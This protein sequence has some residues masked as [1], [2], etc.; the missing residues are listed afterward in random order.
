MFLGIDLGTGSLKA[1]LMAEDG[2]V[3]AEASESYQVNSPQPKWA[4]TDPWVWWRA[5]VNSLNK[6]VQRIGSAKTAIKG[7]GLSGQMH[8]VV[9]CDR[10]LQPL[11]PAILWA[12]GRASESLKV[13]QQLSPSMQR[14]LANPLVVGM[15]GV[16]LLWLKQHE[17]ALYQQA[18]WALQPKDWLR[19]QL[20]GL[21]ASKPHSE[22][23]D[24]SATLLYDLAAD[25]WAWDILEVL[26]LRGEML[27]GVVGSST[28]L[29]SLS[30][31][32]AQ[33]LNLPQNI[34]VI[35]GA[36]DAAA[37]ALGSGLI[38]EGQVQVN[39]GTAMQIFAI[40]YQAHIDPNLKTHLYRNALDGY[41]AMAAMQNAGIVLEQVRKLL[42]LS[43]TEMYEEAFSLESSEGLS[44]LPYITG[45]R[46]PHLNPKAKA[47]WH[48]LSLRHTRG[49]MARS[50]FEGV[51]FALKDGL[52]ALEATGIRAEYLRFVGGGT[53]DKRWQQLVSDIL[54]KP[55]YASDV[56]DSSARGAAL[57][58]LG[59]EALSV[60]DIID[61][62]SQSRG[63]AQPKPSPDLSE[64][65]QRFSALYPR[66]Y[67]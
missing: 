35:A 43:W 21:V 39:I 5:C 37:S 19:V 45:E 20:T 52:L 14:R 53:L 57:A 15:A 31:Q 11:R 67:G 27:G 4:E 38:Q 32:A 61:M 10:A 33:T 48:G 54:A 9:L 50:A 64:A 6:I 62:T 41:Y 23:S 25:D 40:R 58:A 60:Q 42:Q 47:T 29:A 28:P 22:P 16:S 59:L 1:L 36:G 26:G 56:S 3:I 46:T 51:A 30:P 49:H 8:G 17:E 65:Y 63:I 13:Y 2:K 18:V 55:L 12:D 7:I 34:Q 66:L 44:F 24:A